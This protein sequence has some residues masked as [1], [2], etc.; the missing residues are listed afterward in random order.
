MFDSL[1]M[2]DDSPEL[3]RDRPLMVVFVCLE[4]IV[5]LDPTVWEVA[6]G[7]PAE[8]ERRLLQEQDELEWEAGEE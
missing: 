6:D 1:F 8:I 3:R 5:Q 2:R 7:S 4:H